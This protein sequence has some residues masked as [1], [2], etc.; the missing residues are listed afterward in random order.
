[1]SRQIGHALRSSNVVR[2]IPETME[3]SSWEAGNIIRRFSIAMFDYRRVYRF[4]LQ[5][6]G[7]SAKFVMNWG[8]LGNLSPRTEAEME[9]RIFS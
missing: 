4:V 5:R 7:A 6:N 9:A 8:Q 2:E 3:V 1:M